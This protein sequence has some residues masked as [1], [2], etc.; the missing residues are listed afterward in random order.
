M[1]GN[2]DVLNRMLSSV[3]SVELKRND[4]KFFIDVRD[5][6][7][8]TLSHLIGAF[9][10]DAREDIAAARNKAVEEIMQIGHFS[11]FEPEKYF[12]IT[13]PLIMSALM[14]APDLLKRVIKDTVVDISMEQVD[15]LAVEDV[16]CILEA[17]MTRI[18]KER[19][20]EKLKSIF[21]QA[22]GVFNTVQTKLPEPKEAPATESE[23]P[24]TEA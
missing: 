1:A 2:A 11:G 23:K 4:A 19:L 15:Q 16:T 20:A 14:H 8:S 22:T 24:N 17:V 3:F 5:L 7:F 10:T 18:D 13:M 21:L 9:T 12:D 6:P